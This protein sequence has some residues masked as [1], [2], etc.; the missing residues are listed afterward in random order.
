[1]KSF[2]IVCILILVVTFWTLPAF[3]QNLQQGLAGYWKFDET[4]GTTASDSSGNGN[5]GT[6]VGDPQWV[7][8]KIGGALEF[9]GNDYV[10][11]GNGPSLQIQDEITMAFWFQVEAFQNTWEGF[12][13]KGDNSYRTSRGDGTGNATHMGISGT[14]VGGGNGW[15]NGTVIVTDGQWHHMAAVYDG[16][17]G[18]IYIDGALDVASPGTGQI[19]IST[20]DLYIG[21][22]AQAT[23]RFFH[24]LLDDVRIYD[25]AL[26]D[27]E[28]GQVME[29]DETA[30]EFGGKLATKWGVL[31]IQ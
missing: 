5:D 15:F 29:G 12:L 20:Y 23:G 13:A 17:E 1:M 6:F 7:T 9:D 26:T 19:N 28:I 11:C 8:G 2:R 21:E 16:A 27:G 18:R 30:V 22:N 31:K 14:S 10:N 4:S 24:G 25:R 3:A